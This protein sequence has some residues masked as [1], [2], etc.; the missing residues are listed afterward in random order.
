[1]IF[2]NENDIPRLIDLEEQIRI[3]KLNK[4]KREEDQ[5]RREEARI[6][7]YINATISQINIAIQK[8]ISLGEDYASYYIKEKGA[9]K[10]IESIYKLRGYWV[11]IVEDID[12]GRGRVVRFYFKNPDTVEVNAWRDIART[13]T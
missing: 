9:I 4:K 12:Y 10:Y 8:A 1:M 6:Q 7:E 13:I 2:I 3:G 11:K 5:R